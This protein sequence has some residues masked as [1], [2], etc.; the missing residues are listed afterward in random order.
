MSLTEKTIFGVIWNFAEQVGRQGIGLVITLLLAR[1]LAPADF[2]LV[3]MMAVFLAI[4][5]SLM[6]SGFKQALIRKKNVDQV[7]CNTAFFANLSL[8]LI[9][10]VLLFLAAPLIAQFYNEPRLLWLVRV[11]GIAILINAF[12]VVQ[13]ALLTR[14]LNFKAQLQAS[15]P[16]VIISGLV[17]VFL[18][19]MEYGVWALIVQMLMAAFLNTA[20]L[21]KFQ[22][23]RPSSMV[24][25]EA[26]GAMYGFGYKLFLSGLLDITFKNIYVVII[27][28]IFTAPIAGY[29]FFASKIIEIALSQLVGSIQNVTYPALATI[30]QDNLRL[31]AGYRKV[32]QAMTFLV[33]PVMALLA[34]LAGPL[35]SVLL[36]DNWQ[37]AVSYLQLMCIAGML[38]PL[39][40]IN[41]NVIKVKGRSDL[42]LYL[43][44][45][46]KMMEVI[47]IF[48]SYRFG[49]I[50]ILIG[51]IA[52][53]FLA[54][55]PNS[56]FSS[57]LIGY[58]IKEQMEDFMP[59]FVLSGSIGLITY[60]IELTLQWPA[61][62]QLLVLGIFSGISYLTCAHI[63]NLQSYRASIQMITTLILRKN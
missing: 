27:A 51:Q 4:G 49:V 54:Y 39:H 63:L 5:T 58:S 56:Y 12:Q 26:L 45:F 15:I 28:R 32:I 21:W 43:E 9:S 19:S 59:G 62:T 46:K 38:Y 47:V 8:G 2:G 60:N 52:F 30:Q 55:I 16:A 29:Y 50:G 23:W 41:L 17:A 53:S 40:A 42:F 36:P 20:L 1:F 44:I 57:K 6:D 22:G 37:P 24:S 31:K 35:F 33:F 61:L 3:A 11:A 7:D 14:N 13:S 48:I 10:Y 18:A 34:A 25:I